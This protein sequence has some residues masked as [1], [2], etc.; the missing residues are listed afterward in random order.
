MRKADPKGPQKGQGMTYEY[1]PAG[2]RAKKSRHYVRFKSF[3][4][5]FFR[6]VIMARVAKRSTSRPGGARQ[7]AAKEEKEKERKRKTNRLCVAMVVIFGICWL[8]L[9]AINFLRDVEL[10]N[11]FCWSYYHVTFFA[12]HVLAMSSNCYNP[13]LYGWLN[14]AFREEFLRMIPPLATLC[15]GSQDNN[16]AAAAAGNNNHNNQ[17]VAAAAAEE[18]AEE[19]EEIA[20]ANGANSMINVVATVSGSGDVEHRP[21]ETTKMMT[22]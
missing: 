15:K 14:D 13:F 12:C 5:S 17:A 18:E 22:Q 20:L 6:S 19:A 3:L 8:P 11:I 2:S 1:S 7:S 9:N 10:V 4:P 16:A 21:V